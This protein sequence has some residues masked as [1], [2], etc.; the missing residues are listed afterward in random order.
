MQNDRS[1]SWVLA[2]EMGIVKR[3][4]SRNVRVKQTMRATCCIVGPHGESDVWLLR[5]KPMIET[6]GLPI[7]NINI[8]ELFAEPVPGMEEASAATGSS[9]STIPVG[10]GVPLSGPLPSKAT[11]PSAITKVDRN[12]GA[13]IEN[14]LL[15]TFPVQD[16]FRWFGVRGKKE[17]VVW[18]ILIHPWHRNKGYGKAAMMAMEDELR[19]MNIN[20]IVL[21]VF[22]HNSIASTMYLKL[23]FTPVSTKMSKRLS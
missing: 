18:D 17:T 20:S 6:G 22:A 8:K 3:R 9:A 15:N 12:G 5:R 4:Q 19:M 14:A 7:G 11:M 2:P 10:R 16:V 23:G 13:Q 21:N 1:V